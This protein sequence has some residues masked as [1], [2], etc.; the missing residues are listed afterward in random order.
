MDN[1]RGE[2]QEDIL[3]DYLV[4]LISEGGKQ[5]W[6]GDMP[7]FHMDSFDLI[8]STNYRMSSSLHGK[9]D[10]VWL[11]QITPN[12]FPGH[13]SWKIAL[14]ESLRL[15][16]ENGKLVLKVEKLN[17]MQELVFSV[18]KAFL[19][20][21]LCFDCSTIYEKRMGKYW[22]MVF[23]VK[24][25]NF[26]IYSS[27][28]WSFGILTLGNQV[29]R[30]CK[31]LSSIRKHDPDY[32][33]EILVYG[34]ENEE[35]ASYGVKYVEDREHLMNS[36]Y[37]EISRKKNAIIDVASNDNLMIVHDRFALGDDFFSGFERYGYD[38]DFLTV[39]QYDEEGYEFPSY[40][41]LKKKMTAGIMQCNNYGYLYDGQ[42]LNGGLI[43]IKTKTAKRIRFN[44]CLFWK[45]M[46][47]VELSKVCM[48]N[49]II[50]RI[51]FLSSAIV[52]N[53][54]SGFLNNWIVDNGEESESGDVPITEYLK[55]NLSKEILRRTP[56]VADEIY[57]GITD[58]RYL[59]PWHLCKRGERIVIYGAGDVGQCFV[60]QVIRYS[61]VELIGLVDKNW[62]RPEVCGVTVSSP[63][64]LKDWLFDGI[65]VSVKD[66]AVYKSIVENLKKVGVPGEKI[67]WDG[68]VYD[69]DVFLQ[70]V[71]FNQLQSEGD[72]Q[73]IS[74]GGR[75]LIETTHISRKDLGTGIQ[76]TVNELYRYI[77]AREE[78]EVF[79]VVVHAD[80]S[81]HVSDRY[82]EAGRGKVM[83]GE[84]DI[85][86]FPDVSWA[87]LSRMERLFDM[88][89]N[90]CA[91]IYVV[92][93]DLI[94]IREQA[95]VDENFASWVR[96]VLSKAKAIIGI[97]RTVTDDIAAYYKEQ[98]IKR[99]EPLQCYVC[100]LGLNL[101]QSQASNV[102]PI[103]K[104]FLSEGKTFLMVGTIG[105]RK[106]QA[107]VAETFN[108]LWKEERGID[109]KLL[110]IGHVLD[111]KDAGQLRM[112]FAGGL[113]RQKN[114]LWLE[115][116][117]DGELQYAYEHAKV[118]LQASLAEG[119]GL[120]LVE[121]AHYGLPLLC[122]DLPVFHEVT[123]DTAVFFK[124]GDSDSLREK[125]ESW[126]EIKH[127]DSRNIKT[128]AWEDTAQE[129][130]DMFEERVEPY[131]V[132]S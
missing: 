92:I 108:K 38:F 129:I 49:S 23:S 110:I 6:A 47:D 95:A 123:G 41:A 29:E 46:E 26:P 73:V 74:G 22:F 40:S 113:S 36:S 85:L 121:A 45:E 58:N 93:Y 66:R 132:I 102:R 7:P 81:L 10:V 126:D 32:K 11:F 54:R 115:D 65:I 118:L 20:R 125:L 83:L 120:P 3:D 13:D 24:R 72:K 91:K 101:L 104:K 77:S 55:D 90:C 70:E 109:K 31:F 51:N 1:H 67:R 124:K 17:T 131:M 80:G 63:E 5:A 84:Q 61:F 56:R 76:R 39:K 69:R 57:Y 96:L 12:D 97:T 68:D 117:S 88:A 89:V 103:L 107:M 79:P 27:K 48:E 87:Y 64:K 62:Q 82:V 75:I 119:F 42:Y 37:P 19:G 71:Y 114:I 127:P 30:V 100:H 21:H 122:S 116:A 50:P 59:F 33:H 28:L 25:K 4:R 98:S 78:H 105:H 52:L 9:Y 16:K 111:E 112:I 2:F 130:L 128:Y 18:I 86:F 99:K 8:G 106:Q 15:L 35:Y 94:P 44:K 53:M 14:D 60:S 34:P 43:I